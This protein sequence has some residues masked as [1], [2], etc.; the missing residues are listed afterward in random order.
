MSIDTNFHN[1]IKT[2]NNLSLDSSQYIESNEVWLFHKTII[3]PFGYAISIMD[4]IDMILVIFLIHQLYRLVKGTAAIKIFF[5]LIS[6]YATYQLFDILKMKFITQILGLISSVGFIGIVILFQPEIRK[7]LSQIGK[8]NVIKN[9]KLLKIFNKIVKNQKILKIFN[10]DKEENLNIETIIKTCTAF[11]KSKTGAILVLTLT[12][13]LNYI[14]ESAVEIDADITF[15]LLESIFY[16]NSPLHDGAVIIRNN[17]IVAARCVLP[18]SNDD[19]FPGELGMRHRASVGISESS[20]AIT[21][22]VSEQNGKI[23]S[24]FEGKIKVDLSE[25]QLRK[26]LHNKFNTEK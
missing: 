12:D 17:R 23:S 11:Q 26:L 18:V 19:N 21:L 13:N 4:M 22:I 20:D 7:Y 5:G 6:I 15:P 8:G 14:T 2:N 10:S 3:E 16:K 25:K 24:T 9:E 1:N